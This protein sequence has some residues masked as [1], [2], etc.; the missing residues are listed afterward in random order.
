MLKTIDLSRNKLAAIPK[1]FAK[2]CFYFNMRSAIFRICNQHPICASTYDMSYGVHCEN[3][4][5]MQ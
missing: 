3:M 5:S 4:E 2:E 1:G